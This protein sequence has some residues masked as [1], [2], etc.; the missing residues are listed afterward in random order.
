[1]TKTRIILVTL[2]ALS[3]LF[4]AACGGAAPVAPTAQVIVQKVVETVVVEKEGQKVIET[5]EVEKEVVV[6]ATPE[7]TVSPYDEN[8]KIVVWIDTGRKP[9]LDL[10]LKTHPEVADLIQVETVD[11]KLFPA[12][13][14]L[15]NNTGEGWPDVVFAEPNIVGMVAD[16]AHDFPMDLTPWVSADIISKFAAGSLAPCT[17][18]GKLYCLR[19]DLAQNVLWYNKPL[20][21]KFGYKVPTTW[22]DYLALSESVAKEHPGYIMGA[23]GDEQALNSYFWPSICPVSQLQSTSE[24]YINL[25]DPK[26]ARAANLVDKMIANGTILPISP[27]DPAFVKVANDDKLLMM[28]AASWFG[29]FVF[30]GKEDSLYYQ[31]ATGQLAVALPLKW[32]DEE[33]I[34]TGA[35]GGAAWTMSRHTKNPKLAADLI[36]WVTTAIDYQ[37]TA[38]TFPAYLP[39]ADVWAKT[40]ASNPLYAFDPYPIF[41]EAAGYVEPLWGEPRYDIQPTVAETVHEAVKS[42]QTVLS[43][44]PALQ[45]KL[46]PL[47]EAQGYKVITKK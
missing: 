21:D 43:A 18:N 7:P 25:D 34:W 37:G 19:N 30:G 14:L 11:R 41:K 26:C 45:E 17:F 2:V 24:V 36:T 15:F 38:P 32:K 42:G 6:T 13:V 29:G 8:S 9:T 35:Q 44:L 4:L 28:V 5:K 31:T 3:V 47:A 10:Y 33:K 40:Q 12:K 23:F 16:A 46:I 20:M 27:M 39:A 1:M 22:E